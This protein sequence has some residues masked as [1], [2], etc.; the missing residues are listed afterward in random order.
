LSEE[1][2][3]L[4]KISKILLLANADKLEVELAKF[5]STPERK[6]AWILIDSQRQPE[7]LSKSSGMKQSALYNYLKLLSN[8]GL[9]ETP[10]GKAPTKIIDF[11]PASWLELLQ[12]EENKK[13]DDK[14]VKTATNQ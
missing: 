6:K 5:A 11:V 10:Y 14:N 13:Q 7:E 2:K 8:A 12:E 1:L 4:K 3:E 9:I